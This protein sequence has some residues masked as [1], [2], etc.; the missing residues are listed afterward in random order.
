M[1]IWKSHPSICRVVN[2][3]YNTLVW[4]KESDMRGPANRKSSY[5]RLEGFCLHFR[6]NSSKLWFVSLSGQ[7]RKTL[8]SNTSV[9]W[10]LGDTRMHEVCIDLNGRNWGHGHSERAHWPRCCHVLNDKQ[11][12]M[13]MLPDIGLL[14]AESGCYSGS[15]IIFNASTVVPTSFSI[16]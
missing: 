4:E 8:N 2:R 16:V 15:D 6:A 9:V 14:P 13:W 10:F 12:Q 7:K 5:H 3:G 11:R 1:T